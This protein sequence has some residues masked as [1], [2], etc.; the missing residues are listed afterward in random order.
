M[1]PE[2]PQKRQSLLSR[3]R[4]LSWGVSFLSFPSF[5][6]R[7]GTLGFFCSEVEPLPWVEP[8]L[9]FFCLGLEEPLL[10]LLSDLLESDLCSDLFPEDPE[11][12][13]SQESSPLRSQYRASI[14]WMS[15]RSP[16]RVFG[17]SWWTISSLICLVSHCKPD[18][19]V[20]HRPTECMRLAAGT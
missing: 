9:W 3:W 4:C 8:E 16:A 5:E 6:E 7:S 14:A 10:D 18:D 13:V 17:F 19:G 15:F 12:R 2:V 20:L 11:A 1:C